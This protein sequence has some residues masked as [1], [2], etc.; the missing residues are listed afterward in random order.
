[1][2]VEVGLWDVPDKK[3]R[4]SL[5]AKHYIFMGVVGDGCFSVGGCL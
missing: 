5:K 4:G 1:M 3:I 2:F